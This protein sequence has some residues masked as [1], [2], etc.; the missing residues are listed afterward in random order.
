MR[1]EGDKRS[2]LVCSCKD[3]FFWY[4]YVGTVELYPVVKISQDVVGIV[5]LSSSL[6]P[7]CD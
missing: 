1:E 6:H 7:G 5:N 2:L 4:E 3:A